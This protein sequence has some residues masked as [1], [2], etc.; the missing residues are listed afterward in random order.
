MSRRT[1]LFVVI[2]AGI[3][4]GSIDWRRPTA[5]PTEAVVSEEPKRPSWGRELLRGIR[6]HG[7]ADWDARPGQ[8][9][10]S[11]ETPHS[12]TIHHSGETSH[13]VGD[14]QRVGEIIASIQEHHVE[15]RGWADIGYHLIVDAAGRVWE[16]RPLDRIGAHAGSTRLNRGNLGVLLL[17]NFDQSL[18][19]SRQLSTLQGLLDRA[20]TVLSIPSARLYTH[21]AVRVLGGLAPTRCPGRH[22]ARWL[23]TTYPATREPPPGEVASSP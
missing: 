8:P 2:A 6:V 18:P 13:A 20:R 23:V 3:L 7:R 16:G 4:A 17:G 22:L 11:L 10:G 21:S 9:T 14:T 1:V 5:P 19:P 15:R 12:L